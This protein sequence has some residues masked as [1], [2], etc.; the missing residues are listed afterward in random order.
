MDCPQCGGPLATYA[1]SGREAS[2]CEDCGYVGIA[3]EH[4]GEART[5]ESWDD[6]LRRFYHAHDTD[7]EPGVELQPPLSRPSSGASSESWDDALRR[8]YARTGEDAADEDA[9]EEARD[10]ADDDTAHSEDT[11]VEAD[12]G[13]GQ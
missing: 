13:G 3:A 9:E 2:V 4:R 1:L 5:V 12:A 11:G 10:D 7:A 6:A 8:F